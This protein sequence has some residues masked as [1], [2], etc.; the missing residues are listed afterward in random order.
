M[1]TARQ[2]HVLLRLRHQAEDQALAAFAAAKGQVEALRRQVAALEA[3]LIEADRRVR[4]ELG[5]ARRSRELSASMERYRRET[6]A[7]CRR[8]GDDKAMLTTTIGELSVCRRRLLDAMDRRRGME[9]FAAET[10]SRRSRERQRRDVKEQDD[11]YLVR[12][13]IAGTV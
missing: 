11:L 9:H 7:I 5:S 1:A 10:R 12:R 8:L 4:E 13:A 6:G 3:R 2:T